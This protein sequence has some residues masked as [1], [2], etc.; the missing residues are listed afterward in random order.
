MWI[1]AKALLH[2]QKVEL[3]FLVPP[4]AFEPSPVQGPVN[5]VTRV[6]VGRLGD[7]R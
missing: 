7:W 2:F 1:D 5:G 6:E 4:S 3:P